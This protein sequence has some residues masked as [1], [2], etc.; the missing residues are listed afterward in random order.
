MAPYQIC[1][2]TSNIV[3]MY[4]W[5]LTILASQDIN[6]KLRNWNN[7][8][9]S[10]TYLDNLVLSPKIIYQNMLQLRQTHLYKCTPSLNPFL[11]SRVF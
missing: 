8:S 4:I 5:V 2:V 7:A 9:I 6:T 11:V 1:W 10:L 3:S